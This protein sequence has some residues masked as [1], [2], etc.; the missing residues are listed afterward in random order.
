MKKII[1]HI[2][3]QPE[4]VKRHILH[5]LVIVAAIILILL[6]IYSLG[7]SLANPDT[8]TKV[9]NDLKPFATLKNNLIGGFQS[10][11]NPDLNTQPNVQQQ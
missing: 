4:E 2:R 1:H 7:T 5:L 11:A 3:R 9:N 10:I 8:Q 6:W